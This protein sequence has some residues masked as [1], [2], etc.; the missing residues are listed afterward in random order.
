MKIQLRDESREYE[1]GVSVLDIAS[2]ISEG[3][4][5][6]AVAG[7]IDGNLVDLNTKIENDCKLEIITQKDFLKYKRKFLSSMFIWSHMPIT[8]KIFLTAGM[9]CTPLTKLIL[10]VLIPQKA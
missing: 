3:L 2:S 1:S 8:K 9:I 4:A 10:S 7:K 5:R 6:V